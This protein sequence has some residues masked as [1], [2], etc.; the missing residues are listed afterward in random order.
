MTPTLES[1][2]AEIVDTALDE[3]P[4]LV[5]TD[6]PV[7]A[8]PP[9]PERLISLDAFRGFIMLLMASGGLGLAAISKTHP[10][11]PIWRFIGYHTEHVAWTGC[12]F[13]DLIQP[14]FM[15]MVGVAL[16]WSIANRQARGATFPN[17]FGHAILRAIILVVLSIFLQSAF[18]KRT[19]W[20]FP[21]VLAQI[22]LGYPIVFLVAFAQRA[23]QWT[24]AFLILFAYWVAFTS[25]P[26][27][28][29]EF[30]WASVGIPPDWP[31][32]FTGFAAHWEKNFNFALTFDRWFLNLFP[33]EKEW[34]Y[35]AGGYQTLNFVPSI[36]TMIFGVLAG[37]L[38]RSEKTIQQK[39]KHLVLFG[40]AGIVLGKSIELLGL[41]PIVK[42]IWTP[43]WAIFSAGI[44]ALMLA[45]FVAIIEWRGVK[46]WAFPL[47]VAGLNPITLYVM[48]Q[49]MSGFVKN[50]ARIHFGQN[51]FETFGPLYVQTM[52]RGFTL[53]IF[54]LILLWM[55]R[56]KIFIR[57]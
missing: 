51:F 14:A 15:F 16:P 37:Q 36:A 21:N 35:N 26:L 22:G 27:P 24:V 57:I 11:S 45:W 31:H 17:M 42:R 19:D 30:D 43:T 49:I 12:A 34:L 25:H 32:H 28:P 20:T 9:A 10:D 39:L 54:W 1:S 5:E 40:I 38:L 7:P 2:P 4:Q 52:E 3:S 18:Q 56:R 55:Y 47:V 23:W 41:G 53:L 33:R 48:W 44:V 6:P 8:A 50:S 29:P 13:W 46:K